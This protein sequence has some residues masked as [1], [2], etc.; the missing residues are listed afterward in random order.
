MLQPDLDKN[1]P[2][3]LESTDKEGTEHASC[4]R[5]GRPQGGQTEAGALSQPP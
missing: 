2:H 1:V 3:F 4:L 5:I